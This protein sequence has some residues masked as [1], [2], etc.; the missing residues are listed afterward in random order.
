MS[1]DKHQELKNRTKLFALRIIRMSEVMP[2]TH[3]ANVI[4]NRATAKD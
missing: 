4:A 1:L 3:A 2:K